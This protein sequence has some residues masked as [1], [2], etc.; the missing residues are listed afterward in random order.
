ML[1]LLFVRGTKQHKS[2]KSTSCFFKKLPNINTN[3]YTMMR[4]VRV[5]FADILKA[6]N[7]NTIK[8]IIC[9]F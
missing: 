9:N 1:Q 4:V 3:D 5:E 7:L 6:V 2:S 8:I